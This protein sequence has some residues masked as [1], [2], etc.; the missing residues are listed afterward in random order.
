MSRFGFV[1]G[2]FAIG[3]FGMYMIGL[4]KLV[5][6]QAY[7]LNKVSVNVNGVSAKAPCKSGCDLSPNTINATGIVFIP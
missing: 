6:L 1:C 2:T 7:R 4:Q 3:Q 5:L